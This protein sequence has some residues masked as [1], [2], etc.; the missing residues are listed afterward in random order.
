VKN[1]TAFFGGSFNP[2]HNGHLGV[3][4]GALASNL[5]QKIIW[6][7]SWSQPHKQDKKAAPFHHRL[8]MVDILIAGQQNMQ[9][10]DLEERLKLQPSYTSEVLKYFSEEL[11]A[12]E[13]AALLIGAD[14]LLALHTWHNAEELVQK[15]FII[16]YPRPGKEI[17]EKV[18]RCHW[19]EENVEKLLSGVINGAF[20]EISSTGIRNSLVKNTNTGNINNEDKNLLNTRI[21]E[22]CRKYDLYE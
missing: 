4:Q 10:S 1:L 8:A 2:P 7:P 20:F 14:S 19:S 16:T 18:L 22:Y 17:T 9:S 15:Y 12:D 6:V 3:A 11:P 13:E 21:E 5:C